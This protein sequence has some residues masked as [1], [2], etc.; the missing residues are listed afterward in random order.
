MIP[1]L[2]TLVGGLP[3]WLV[4]TLKA[5]AAGGFMTLANFVILYAS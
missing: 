3:A 1:E 2:P 4:L 5:L